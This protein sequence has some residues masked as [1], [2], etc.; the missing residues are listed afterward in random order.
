MSNRLN[1]AITQW[2][3]LLEGIHPI[4]FDELTVERIPDLDEACFSLG[5]LD[6]HMAVYDHIKYHEERVK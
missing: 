6:W 3:E 4:E 1:E 5:E 2:A